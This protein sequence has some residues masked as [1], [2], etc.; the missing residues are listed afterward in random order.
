MDTRIFKYQARQNLRGKWAAAIGVAAF[1]CVMGGL[2][3]GTSFIPQIDSNTEIAFLQQLHDVL[4]Q[5]IT[6]G[7]T[8]ISFKRG[9]LGI[10]AFFLGGTVQLGYAH[11][12][13][14]QYDGQEADWHDLFSQ[15]HRYGQ[16][17]AQM[18]LRNLYTV[19][20]SLLLI[21]PG[22]VKN[23][24][25]AMTPYIMIEEPNLTVSEA[26]EKSRLMMTGH[27]WDLFVLRF[28]FIGWSILSAL[29]LQL[30]NLLLNP[31]RNAAEA[32]LYRE[33]KR[34]HPNL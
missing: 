10:V 27:K 2:M 6:I 11:F 3:E 16:G 34:L 32:A 13:L 18:F 21:I 29:T 5:G 19:L 23:L 25:Y 24:S 28:S 15:F 12:L 31:Y 14:K 22:M 9:I 8:T 1:A 33:L 4:E 17:F 7:N 26:I 20:W 30:G